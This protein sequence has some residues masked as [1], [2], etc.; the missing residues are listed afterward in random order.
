MFKRLRIYLHEMYPLPSRLMAS[1]GLFVGVYASAIFVSRIR[2]S[3]FGYEEIIGFLTVFFL[4]LSLRVVDE[5]KDAK[6]DLVNFPNRPLPSGRVKKSD[7]ITL[8]SAVV[9]SMLVANLVF[10]PNK[11]SFL[12]MFVY[13]CLMSVWFFAKKYIQPNLLAALVTH[14]PI[15]L[16]IVFY[17]L[18]IAGSIYSFSI[19]QPT[20]LLIAFIFYIP[21]LAWEVSRKIRIAKEEN[22]Y[23][24]YS[25]IFGRSKAIY[26]VMTV[27]LLQLV[28]TSIVFW[29]RDII[30]VILGVLIFSIYAVASLYN[31]KY[32]QSINYGKIARSYIYCF[33]ILIVTVSLIGVL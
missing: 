12:V 5:F 4:L 9:A 13:A 29:Q 15:Q 23:I 1:I 10:M 26:I 17:I 24:T 7:L 19:F 32:P 28:A 14:N 11:V 16:L 3:H 18:S 25:R 21:G 2:L 27:L 30:I 31:I 22:Q 8:G 6:T 20:I 33:Q